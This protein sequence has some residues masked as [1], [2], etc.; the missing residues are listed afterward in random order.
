MNARSGCGRCLEHPDA[1]S[2]AGT[3]RFARWFTERR[4]PKTCAVSA[5]R[6][7]DGQRR[8]QMEVSALADCAS[9]LLLRWRPDDCSQEESPAVASSCLR[10]FQMMSSFGEC[11]G[12]SR[13]KRSAWPIG[14]AEGGD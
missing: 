2:S 13:W 10:S 11:A 8:R 4:F 6:E 3:W 5:E 9:A 12:R 1:A 14:G 7:L